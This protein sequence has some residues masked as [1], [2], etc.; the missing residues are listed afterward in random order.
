VTSALLVSVFLIATCGLVYELLAGTLASYVLGDTVTQFSTV[1]GTYMFSMG[2]GSYISKYILRGLVARFVQVELMVGL[3]GGFSTTVLFWAFGQQWGFQLVLYG[4]VGVIG[5]LVGLEIPLLL[6]ILKDRFEFRDLVSEVL[7]LDYLGALAASLLFPLV[8][9][10][11]LGLIR[12][13]FL[14]GMLNVGVALWGT[15][16]FASGTGA[17]RMLRAQCIV[18]L[19]LLL[20]G[21]VFSDRITTYTEQGLYTDDI[22]LARSSPYQRIVLTRRHGDIRLFLNSHLQFSSQ[23]EYRYHESL[24]HPG[25]ASVAS[26]RHVLVLGGG[27]GMAIREILKDPR[28][29][30]ITHVDLDPLMIHLFQTNPLLVSLNQGSLRSPK[31]HIVNADA[32]V[33]LLGNPDAFDFIVVDFPDPSNFSLGKLYTTAFYERLARHLAPGGRI[34]V[35]STSPLFARRSYWCIADTIASI[36]LTT[37]PYHVY[38]PSFGEWGFVLAGRGAVPIPTRFPPGLRFLNSDIVASLFEFSNDM[39]PIAVETNHLNNQI[40]V[41]YYDEDWHLIAQ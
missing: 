1:I 9:V 22:I 21:F 3:V 40:L 18:A 29:E 23:D 25:L 39:R 35:Q 28:V 38:V 16:I 5:I 10:P 33:W 11:R 19:A 12:S 4:V 13:A 31:V 7:S 32:F 17:V 6:R 8:L 15:W 26:P 14:F 41:H 27:D 30:S 24:V 2:I 37:Q 34:V 20:A 36:G